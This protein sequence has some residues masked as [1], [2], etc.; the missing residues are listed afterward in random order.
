MA[1][2]EK[3]QLLDQ[4]NLELQR[5]ASQYENKLAKVEETHRREMEQINRRHQESLE[6]L[7]KVKGKG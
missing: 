2:R 3:K 5:Q 7:T 4:K 6:N 1:D